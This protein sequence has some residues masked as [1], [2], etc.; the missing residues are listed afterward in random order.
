MIVTKMEFVF[1]DGSLSVRA[2]ERM[3]RALEPTT[4]HGVLTRVKERV[5]DEVALARM[6]LAELLYH[7]LV[8]QAEA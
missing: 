6:S 8:E 7:A 3:R 4:E 5:V 1:P 2:G